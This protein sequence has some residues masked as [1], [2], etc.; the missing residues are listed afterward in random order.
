M[1]ELV[2]NNGGRRLF[3]EDLNSLQDHLKAVQEIFKGESPFILSGIQYSLVSGTTYNIS[4][5]YVW[6]GNKIRYF[7]G[8]NSVNVS[9]EQYINT[10]DSTTSRLY[11]DNNQRTALEDFGTALVA[12]AID[13]T[14]SL[15]IDQI[16]DA[17]RYWKNVLG[18]KFLSL[19]SS[20]T[21][22]V[23][24]NVSMQGTFTSTGTITTSGTINASQVSTTNLSADSGT[25]TALQSSS[26]VTNTLNVN[27][28]AVFA[29]SLKA[30]VYEAGDG[31]GAVINNDGSI[32][33]DRVTSD[34][35]KA[36][37]VDTS[38]LSDGAVTTIKID[39]GAVEHEKLATDSVYG[40]KIKD[41]AITTNKIDILAVT[42]DKIA[43][44]T[45]TN[46]KL[47][48]ESVYGDKIKQKSI[49]DTHIADFAI[50]NRNLGFNSVDTDNLNFEALEI[51]KTGGDSFNAS[52]NLDFN[53]EISGF[54]NTNTSKYIVLVELST[55]SSSSASFIS[56]I[57]N[58]DRTKFNLRISLVKPISGGAL[59]YYGE[60]RYTVL[61]MLD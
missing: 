3:N 24:S 61:K 31:S 4:E 53:K 15:R 59:Q 57:E 29:S 20:E 27:S 35:I 50:Q 9:T 22:Y 55:S 7:S 39:N 38:E 32:S 19:D 10:A 48:D 46:N 5:G 12:T 34:S 54:V 45:I 11:E 21:Q 33:T 41:E 43:N 51:I 16:D 36:G 47:E 44:E 17:R 18:D 6:L 1:K 25:V 8:A 13:S 56:H 60:Y 49:V 2:I 30:A 14:N 26:I 40:D 28:T 58:K 42:G 37:A 23:L 52:Y